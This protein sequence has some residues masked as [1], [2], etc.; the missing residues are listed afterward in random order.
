MYIK[1]VLLTEIVAVKTALNFKTGK[2]VQKCKD[3]P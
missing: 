1:Y 3:I 2:D